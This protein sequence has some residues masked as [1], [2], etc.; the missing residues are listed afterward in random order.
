[1]IGDRWRLCS[2]GQDEPGVAKKQKY[3]AVGDTSSEWGRIA[4][5][6]VCVCVY[7]CVQQ[8][9]TLSGFSPELTRLGILESSSGSAVPLPNGEVE[10]FGNS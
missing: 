8:L 4:A 2:S 3:R 7:V 9:A 10:S 6:Q 1:L 5:K